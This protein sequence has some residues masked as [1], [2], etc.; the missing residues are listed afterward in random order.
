MSESCSICGNDVAWL[1]D[2]GEKE[3]YWLCGECAAERVMS[4]FLENQ[5]LLRESGEF[6]MSGKQ[7]TKARRRARR[8]AMAMFDD[9][10]EEIHLEPIWVRLRIAWG[11]IRGRKPII[12]HRK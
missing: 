4:G 7:V 11:V 2:K 8:V 10:L 5:I 1:V 12:V 9:W 3:T 6:A